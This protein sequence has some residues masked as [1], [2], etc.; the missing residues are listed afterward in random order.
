[1]L[2]HYGLSRGMLHDGKMYGPNPEEFD[3]ERFLRPGVEDPT[4]VFGYGRR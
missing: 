3:P 2:S 4:V 1:M